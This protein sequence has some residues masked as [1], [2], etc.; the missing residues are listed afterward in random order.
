MVGTCIRTQ[1]VLNRT[2]AGMKISVIYFQNKFRSEL[3]NLMTSK[4][5]SIFALK[6]PDFSRKR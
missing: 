5:V 4:Y 6:I 2:I 3:F 1:T